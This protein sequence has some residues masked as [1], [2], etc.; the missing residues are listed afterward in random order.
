VV[1]HTTKTCDVIGIEESISSLTS[2]MFF[3]LNEKQTQINKKC[4]LP[5]HLQ[6]ALME[7]ILCVLPDHTRTP[8]GFVLLSV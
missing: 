8:V 3:F 5:K 7:R 2:K 1:C 6:N 4:A